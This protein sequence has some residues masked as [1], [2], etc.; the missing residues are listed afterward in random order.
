[1][2]VFLVSIGIIA[3]GFGA[4][5]LFVGPT[6]TQEIASILSIGFGVVAIGIG[7]VIARLD[8]LTERKRG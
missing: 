6:I 4:V 7:G 1:M 3:A 5:G 8:R 2:V